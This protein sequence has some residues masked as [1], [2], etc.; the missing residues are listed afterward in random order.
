MANPDSAVATV[1]AA[2]NAPKMKRIPMTPAK[3]VEAAGKLFS[4]GKFKEAH[5]VAKQIVQHNPK[6]ADGYNVLGVSLNAIGNSK[7]GAAMLQKAISLAPRNASF[8]ANLGEIERQRGRNV[9]ARQALQKAIELDPKQASAYNNIGILNFQRKAYREAVAAYLKAIELN[10]NF[11]EAYNN[12]AN[13]SRFIGEHNKA[14]GYYHKALQHRE[15]YPEAYNNLGS[16]LKDL[17]KLAEAEHA[18]R[19]AMSQNSNY[20]EAYNN[21]ALLQFQQ[22]KDTDALRTLSDALRVQPNNPDT[23]TTTARVQLRRNN[24]TATE[25]AA[26]RALAAKADHADAMIVLGQ[27]YHETDRYDEATA[28]LEEALK[29]APNSPEAHNFYGVALKSVGRLD[30]GRTEILKALELNSQNYGAYANLNDLVDFKDAPELVERMEAIFKASKN[31]DDPRLMALH[32]G[33]AKALEDIGQHPRALD[34]YLKGTKLKRATLA[35]NE[36]ETLQF[37]ADIKAAF[38]AELFDKRPFAGLPTN[39]LIFIVGMPRSGSTLVEQILSSHPDV[40]GA[41]EVKYLARAIGQLRDR[42]P[43]MAKYPAMLKELEKFHFETL[44]KSYLKQIEPTAGDHKRITD[45]LLTNYFFVG[46]IHL[47]FPHAKFVHTR[48]NPVDTCLSGFTKLFKDDMP[49][50]YDFGELGRYYLQ[51][52]DLMDHWHNVLPEGVLMD[53]QYEEVVADVEGNARKLIEH[54]GLDWDPACVEFHKSSRPVKTASVAQVRKPVYTGSVERFRKYGP[55]IQPLI[56]A[57]KYDATPD[58]KPAGPKAP[59]RKKSTKADAG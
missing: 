22:G 59:A 20:I 21:L 9:E 33:F 39:R 16:L 35:Y 29:H 55:G 7:E 24:F 51:Y 45:K 10:P 13:A 8:Y 54:V 6:M 30:E 44:G 2:A 11:A 43:S 58:A 48:R 41:G 47:I 1:P 32:F 57:L 15:I 52:Q 53:V 12:V 17:G 4:Q 37:F 49:H 18:F 36:Q 40:F 50:S 26:R 31:H 25:Q 3:A 14:L 19:K 5:D 27:L 23:L 42:F 34:H 56:D 46:L 38:T 28:M